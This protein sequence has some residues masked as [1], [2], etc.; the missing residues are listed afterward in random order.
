MQDKDSNLLWEAYNNDPFDRYTEANPHN[1]TEWRKIRDLLNDGSEPLV[2]F[3]TQ[4]GDKWIT[5]AGFGQGQGKGWPS[6]PG[7]DDLSIYGYLKGGKD[8]NINI[9]DLTIKIIDVVV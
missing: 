5:A 1:S 8:I 9:S 7:D 6:D 2:K 4:E 3:E